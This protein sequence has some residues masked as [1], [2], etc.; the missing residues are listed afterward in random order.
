M[1][2]IKIDFQRINQ[3]V[4]IPF[5]RLCNVSLHHRHLRRAFRLQGKPLDKAQRE[6]KG[7]QYNGGDQRFPVSLN[8]RQHQ[9]AAHHHQQ[10]V[11]RLHTHHRGQA[12]Q[13][14][15]NLAVAE[16]QPREAG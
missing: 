1:R 5:Q 11:D 3:L 4:L 8:Q 13:R 15:I 9:Q 12:F 2:R 10:E 14:A 7:E 16:L 6:G